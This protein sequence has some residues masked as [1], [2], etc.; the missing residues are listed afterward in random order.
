MDFIQK[1]DNFLLFQSFIPPPPRVIILIPVVI[2]V[3]EE[4][5]FLQEISLKS[6]Q[7]LNTYFFTIA[8]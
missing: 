3:Y 8:T 4:L 1:L 7:N 6:P 2:E 5:S